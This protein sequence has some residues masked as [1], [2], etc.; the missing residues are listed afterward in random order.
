M[1]QVEPSPAATWVQTWSPVTATGRAEFVVSPRP[2]CPW[3]LNP[4]HIIPPAWVTPQVWAQ[5]A[6]SWS[7]DVPPAT[8]VGR[9][10][11]VTVPSPS[12]PKSLAP[13]QYAAPADVTAHECQP[14][15]VTEFQSVRVPTRCG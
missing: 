13:Q 12:S 1:P 3:R 4:Q 8:T 10:R 15:V 5:A 11:V 2:S 6:L 14:P 9:V 7:H